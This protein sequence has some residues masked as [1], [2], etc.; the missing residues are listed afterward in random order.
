MADTLSAMR[1]RLSAADRSLFDHWNAA[2][3]RL[4]RAVIN[5]PGRLSQAEH[6]KQ[7][8]AIEAEREKL[9]AE[10]GRRSVGFQCSERGTVAQKK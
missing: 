8:K 6:S 1:G 9:E 7:I 4:A 3:A 2:T 10:I 5:G